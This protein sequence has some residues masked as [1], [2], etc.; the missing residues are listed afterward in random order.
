MSYC[1]ISLNRQGPWGN[2]A[3]F[4]PHSSCAWQEC[5]DDSSGP[6]K[7]QYLCPMVAFSFAVVPEPWREEE[8]GEQTLFLFWACHSDIL[9]HMIVRKSNKSRFQP[10][11]AYKLF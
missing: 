10:Q 6:E 5:L 7:D 8:T 4:I 11:I 1:L 2:Q 3:H 9:A